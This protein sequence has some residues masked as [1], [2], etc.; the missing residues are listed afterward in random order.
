MVNSIHNSTKMIYKNLFKQVTIGMVGSD[1]D[2]IVTV[3]CYH[4]AHKKFHK[5]FNKIKKVITFFGL[6]TYWLA[7]GN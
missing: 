2:S 7:S 6:E 1:L 5:L 3:V 4:L